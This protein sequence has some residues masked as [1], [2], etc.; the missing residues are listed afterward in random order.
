MVKLVMFMAQTHH[1]PNVF[2]HLPPTQACDT[3]MCPVDCV[4]GDWT[5]WICDAPQQC[6]RLSPSAS[7]TSTRTR[8]IATQAMNDGSQCQ[9][10]MQ[11]AKPC[12]TDA[13]QVWQTL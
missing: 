2:R 11:E 5:A 12:S 13:C 3:N 7:G 10:P 8:S 1:H 4:F 9:G 6:T